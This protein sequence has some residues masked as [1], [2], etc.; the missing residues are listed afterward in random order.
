MET[1][2][3]KKFTLLDNSVDTSD[4]SLSII[5][6]NNCDECDDCSEGNQQGS[7]GIH[8]L[9]FGI[10]GG[11]SNNRY[12]TTLTQWSAINSSNNPS[13]NNYFITLGDIVGYVPY[14]SA[15][16]DLNLGSHKFTSTYTSLGVNPVDGIA[17]INSSLATLNTKQVSPA[18]HF[19]GSAFLTEASTPA[20]SEF[21]IYNAPINGA[22]NVTGILTISGPTISNPL[23]QLTSTG[24]GT[25]TVG[26]LVVQRHIVNGTNNASSGVGRVYN[27]TTNLSPTADND[28]LIGMDLNTVFSSGQGIGSIKNLIGGT[29]YTNGFYHAISLT[30]NTNIASA[31]TATADITVSGGFVTTV[32]IINPGA[33]HA[34][35]NVMTVQSSLIGGTGSGFSF[36]VASNYSYTGVT[37]YQLRTWGR[38]VYATDISNQ[39]DTLDKINKGY[40]DSNYITITTDQNISG[41]KT[42]TNIT[43][44][45][46]SNSDAVGHT[47]MSNSFNTFVT[48][49]NETNTQIKIGGNSLDGYLNNFNNS[50][51]A[52]MISA[53]ANTSLSFHRTS[54]VVT[55]ETNV[56]NSSIIIEDAILSKGAI[57][58]ADY[59]ANFENNSL[60]SKKYVDDAIA[61]AIAAI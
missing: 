52:A 61:A 2:S 4:V 40:A 12:H 56:F 18:L 53:T 20:T 39:F 6:D 29:N 16:A 14:E 60:V 33:R 50:L 28:V 7:T 59:S 9:L 15:I 47:T 49:A 30:D 58:S 41:S 17:L 22:S 44:I 46:G 55:S 19:K 21:W 23:F 25:L 24:G 31:S 45:Q 5:S 35:N 42:F 27:Q 51:A 8:N 54:I 26:G 3:N 13:G 38:D 57:Y 37:N 48:T 43:T 10:Q 36:Q 1:G 32:T 34:I 11:D